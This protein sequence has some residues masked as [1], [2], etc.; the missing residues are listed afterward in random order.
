MSKLWPALALGLFTA[1]GALAQQDRPTPQQQRM[2]DCNAQAGKQNLK[3]DERKSYMSSC[4]K[5][6]KPQL[7]AQQEKMKSCNKQAGD[8]KLKGDARKKFMSQCLKG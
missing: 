2:K 1:A 8:E 3:G 6:D 7:T 5:G 4:L